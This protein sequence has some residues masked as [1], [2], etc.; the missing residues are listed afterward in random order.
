LGVVCQIAG[1]QAVSYA[2]SVAF[3]TKYAR[4]GGYSLH[5]LGVHKDSIF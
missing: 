4:L 2:K 5:T 3:Y 1:V